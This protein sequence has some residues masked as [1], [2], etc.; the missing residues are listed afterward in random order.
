MHERFE[1]EKD[2]LLAAS[3]GRLKGVLSELDAATRE[4]DL[5]RADQLDKML[6]A[7]MSERDLLTR[8]HT[9]PWSSTTF[10]GFASALLLPVV[11]FIIT[12]VIERLL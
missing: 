10:R 8:L 6:H 1:A 5:S 2:R 12:R 11:I 9:W 4:A 3:T 7:V